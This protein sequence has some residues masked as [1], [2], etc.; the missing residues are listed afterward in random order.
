MVAELE[1]AFDSLEADHSV[2]AVVLAGR[3]ASFCAG[4]D[5]KWLQR[6]GSASARSKAAHELTRMFYR[7]HT[8]KKPTVARVHGTSYAGGLGLIAACDVAIAAQDAEFCLAEVKLGLAAATIMPYLV[9]TIGER[10]ARRYVLSAET[11]TAAEAYRIG[12][13]HDLARPEELDGAVNGILGHIM[14]GGPGAQASAKE[15]IASLAGLSITPAIASRTAERFA[16]LWN[17]SEGREGIRALLE[18]RPSAWLA[19]KPAAGTSRRR[20]KVSP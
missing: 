7:L 5:L 16:E 19:S 10:H 14:Q 17:S 2:R 20:K 15:L 9:H 8:L 1:Y 3:G 6:V 11:F 4:I 13:V 12:L 18:K